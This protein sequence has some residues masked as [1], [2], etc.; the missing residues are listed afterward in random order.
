MKYL[1]QTLLTLTLTL[2]L[3]SAL[4]AQKFEAAVDYMDHI[5]EQYG[6]LHADQWAYTQ[7]IARGKSAKKVEKKRQELLASMLTAIRKV[8]S[9]PGWQGDKSLRD[10]VVKY[11]KFN[12]AVINQ[13]YA[14]IVD[15]EAIAEQSYDAMEAYLL[16]KEEAGNKL[17]NTGDRMIQQQKIFAANN[18]INL[19]DKETD[20]DKKMKVASDV[21]SQYNELYLIF[22]K[23][24]KQEAYFL[25]AAAKGD[26]SAMEQ[27]ANALSNYA[28]TGKQKLAAIQPING[29]Q[30]LKGA[31]TRI[32]NFYI[33]EG[34][35]KFPKLTDFFLKKENYEKIRKSY[36]EIKKPTQED[37]DRVNGAMK[38]YNDSVNIYNSTNE[39][40]N[41]ARGGHIE[42]WNNTAQKFLDKNVPK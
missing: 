3:F 32:L 4:Q 20:L 10:S 36:D 30:S 12:Y 19:V 35:K 27:N 9:M 26:V 7:T 34:D 13:D 42:F 15:M 1:K 40:L 37:V 41:K 21:F 39:E 16:A 25:D 18:N 11:L 29:D 31:T 5:S 38:A 14:K 23:C 22:F 28:K 6:V 8:N 2:T 17:Q 24:Y 33:E